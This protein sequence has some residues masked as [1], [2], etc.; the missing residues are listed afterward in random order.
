M[1]LVRIDYAITI[2]D[3]NKALKELIYKEGQDY[4]INFQYSIMHV[5]SAS[6]SSEVEKYESL[7]KK[8]LGSRVF[9]LNRN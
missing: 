1:I 9:G 5:L 3:G 6:R 8:K 4:K 2:H 7:Y